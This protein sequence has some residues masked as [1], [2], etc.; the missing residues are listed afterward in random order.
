MRG[1]GE[2]EA[3]I[4]DWLWSHRSAATVR[5]VH[6]ALQ[7]DAPLAYTTVMTM[8]DNLHRKGFL[9]RM[10]GPRA[11]YVYQPVHT[12]E[13]YAASLMHEALRE[14]GDRSQA[15]VRF[16]EAMS[17]AQTEALRL[18]LRAHADRGK[19]P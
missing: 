18:A 6:T 17:R 12:R 5:E 10:L 9:Q 1:L 19:H 14:A 15:L 3:E 4:M 16:V 13:Q 8:M 7:T 2:R 11:A